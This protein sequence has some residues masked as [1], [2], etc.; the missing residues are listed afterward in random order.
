MPHAAVL[1]LIPSPVF[2]VAV[3]DGLAVPDI[4]VAEPEVAMVAVLDI[5]DD[6]DDIDDIDAEA[7]DDALTTAAMTPPWIS[8]G[9]L[10]VALDDAFLYM[11]R[12]MLSFEL[13]LAGG[14]QDR[15]IQD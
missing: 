12:V 4:T 7:I 6:M 5:M 11:A 2:A 15:S 1:F 13:H 14:S 3:A 8:G 9:D 10:V